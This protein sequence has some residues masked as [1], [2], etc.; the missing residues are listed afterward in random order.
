MNLVIPETPFAWREPAAT[1]AAAVLNGG[2]QVSRIFANK[3][4]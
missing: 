4:L 1:N 3:A 2:G